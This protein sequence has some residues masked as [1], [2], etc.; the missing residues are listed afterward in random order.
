MIEFSSTITKLVG[1]DS[2]TASTNNPCTGRNTTK[3]AR[4]QLQPT[5]NAQKG[6]IRSEAHELCQFSSVFLSL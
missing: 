5:C 1:I 6:I 3:S 4:S 2:I